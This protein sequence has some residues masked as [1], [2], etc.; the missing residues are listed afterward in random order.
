[1]HFAGICPRIP[2]HFID[3]DGTIADVTPRDIAARF[4]IVNP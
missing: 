1:L 4:P 2:A 3:P